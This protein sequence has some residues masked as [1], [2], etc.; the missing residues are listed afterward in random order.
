[1]LLV[2]GFE[3]ISQSNLTSDLG[4]GCMLRSGQMLLTQVC[5]VSASW[6]LI[7]QK[8]DSSQFLSW[9]FLSWGWR[10]SFPDA[11]YCYSDTLPGDALQHHFLSI[12]QITLVA[13]I[14]V[15]PFGEVLAVI[16]WAYFSTLNQM[17]QIRGLTVIL[18]FL[19][20]I[21]KVLATMLH[22]TPLVYHALTVAPNLAKPLQCCGM[23]HQ[24]C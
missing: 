13:S 20:Q 8:V 1:M 10:A 9:D 5:V 6:T 21:W 23:F 16:R 2:T 22:S 3:P 18:H 15:P 11:F 4:W 17:I 12:L 19:H 14:D 7:C 24:L